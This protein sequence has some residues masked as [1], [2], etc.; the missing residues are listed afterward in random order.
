MQQFITGQK[1]NISNLFPS[2]KFQVKINLDMKDCEIDI[3]CFGVDNQNQL[4]DDRYFIFYNQLFSPEKAIIK[5]SN[6]NLFTIDL[7]LLPEKI[8]RLIFTASIDGTSVMSQLKNGR[9]SFLLDNQEK[10]EYSFLGNQFQQEKAIIIT[11]IYKYNGNWKTAIVAKG[12][13]GGLS[14]LLAHFGGQ[15]IKEESSPKSTSVSLSKSEKVQKIVLEKA[16]H[17]ID[18]TK[19][20]VISLEKKNALNIT[21]QVVLVLDRS[22]S[23][24]R[25]Y[26]KGKVQK[27]LDRVLPLALLFDDNRSLESWAFA[28]EYKE[29]AE[30]TV[31]NIKDYVITTDN[32][33]KNWNVGGSNNEPKVMEA[34]CQKHQK[35]CLPVYIIFISDGGVYENKKIKQ[36]IKNSAVYPM[37]WQFIGIGGSNYGILEK[38]DEMEG[39]YIDNAN[40]FALDDIDSISDEDLYDRL[41]N[42]FPKWLKEAKQ[43]N[44][45]H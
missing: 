5:E 34:L 29:L 6:S 16:P 19:K 33:W 11:E 28:N 2:N 24:S 45:L 7:N 36:I 18:L 39:R 12:F 3:S 14:A 44:I 25:Q 22:G 27:I 37:F 9:L 13:N 40:F 4:S 38:L 23:M 26:K 17:L 20:A 1:I 15:E 21:A 35:S 8:N 41:M 30:A 43:K 10:A 42:E 31:E 32:G